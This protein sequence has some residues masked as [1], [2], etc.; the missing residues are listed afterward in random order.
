MKQETHNEAMETTEQAESVETVSAE[1]AESAPYEQASGYEAEIAQLKQTAEENYQKYLRTQAD[2][3]NFRRRSRQEKEEFAKYASLKLIEGLLPIVD[4]FERAVNA[5]REQKDFDSLYK[6]VEMIGRQ[7]LQLL[8]QE[9]VK[10]I[11]AAGQPFNP[12]YHQAVMQVS[13][14][15]GVDPGTVVEE[16]QKGY[17]MKEK[18]I[19]PAMVKVSE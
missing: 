7:I 13:A 6:G 2:F 14:E 8:D 4:N 9:G 11:E 3:D 10:P 15:E 5:S 1:S 16:L 19:R 18:V 17:I 12:E